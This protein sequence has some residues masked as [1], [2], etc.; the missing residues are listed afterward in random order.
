[1]S[2][3]VPCLKMPYNVWQLQEVGDSGDENCLPALNLIRSTKLH[4]STEPA[5]FAKRLLCNVIFR[6]ICLNV[7]FL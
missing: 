2:L 6:L 1:L 7:A 3:E 5:F 4:L